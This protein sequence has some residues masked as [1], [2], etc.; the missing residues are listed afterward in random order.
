[1][2][3]NHE[4]K[5]RKTIFVQEATSHTYNSPIPRNWMNNNSTLLEFVQGIDGNATSFSSAVTN[6]VTPGC[7]G[8]IEMNNNFA[9]WSGSQNFINNTFTGTWWL[10]SMNCVGNAAAGYNYIKIQEYTSSGT[11]TNLKVNLH[12]MIEG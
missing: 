1:L 2:V 10:A 7:I 3:Y 12:G 9:I 5:L 6:Y 8:T 11:V 4:N